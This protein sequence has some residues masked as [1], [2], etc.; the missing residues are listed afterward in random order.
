MWPDTE[1]IEYGDRW[2]LVTRDQVDG[3]AAM[4]V[5]MSPAAEASQHV[6]NEL[7]RAPWGRPRVRRPQR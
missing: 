7:S 2:E 5:V 1:R 3:C 6:G 4:V